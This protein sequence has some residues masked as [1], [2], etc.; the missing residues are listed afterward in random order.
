[1]DTVLKMLSA[2][3]DFIISYPLI[4]GGVWLFINVVAFVMYGADKAKAKKGSWRTPEAMLISVALLFGGVGALLGMLTFRHKTK[5]I[6]FTLTVP[7]FATVQMA[8]IIASL[9][10]SQLK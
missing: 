3:G 10:S 6:K 5:H 8:V 2:V 9:V 7:L 1:M 4:V